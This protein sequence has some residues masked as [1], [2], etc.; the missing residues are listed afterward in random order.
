MSEYIKYMIKKYNT[1]ASKAIK[2]LKMSYCEQA[3]DIR[4]EL[5]GS[6]TSY[7]EIAK[8]I[9]NIVEPL[10]F[11]TRIT[12][13]EIELNDLIKEL[14]DAAQEIQEFLDQD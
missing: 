10:P 1:F 3:R 8:R 7:L 13:R 2:T 12:T 6:R 9:E 11:Q 14:K 5:I 4:S